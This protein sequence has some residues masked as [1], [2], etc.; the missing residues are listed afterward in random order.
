MSAM[1]SPADRGDDPPAEALGYYW[2]L[3]FEHA[4]ELHAAV[5]GCQRHIDPDLFDLMP[6]SG[7]HLTVDRIARVGEITPEHLDAIA[8]AAVLTCQAQHPLAL[9]L[10]HVTSL[11]GAIG[12]IV[13]PA[14]AVRALR[15]RVRAATLAIFPDAPVKMSASAPHITIAYPASE[16]ASA[17]AAS[18]ATEIDA[19]I[20]PIE[21]VVTEA[22]LV[23]L[24]RGRRGYTWEVQARIPL[25]AQ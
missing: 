13:T 2:F 22:V 1:A 24:K 23:W 4:L 16:N 3:T 17:V 6:T 18:T 9:R 14:D 19:V 21:V 7:L 8:A 11:R 20:A 25:R 10:A 15:D 12:F 5:K